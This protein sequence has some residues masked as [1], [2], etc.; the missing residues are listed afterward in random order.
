MNYN[1]G[2]ILTELERRHYLYLIGGDY[3]QLFYTFDH[4][5][6]TRD[7]L[8]FQGLSRIRLDVEVSTAERNKQIQDS[9]ADPEYKAMLDFM[10]KKRINARLEHADN[11]VETCQELVDVGPLLQDFSGERSFTSERVEHLK[12]CTWLVERLEAF[13]DNPQYKPYFN[14]PSATGIDAKLDVLGYSLFMWIMPRLTGEKIFERLHPSL[15]EV[16]GRIRR[17]NRLSS[18]AVAAMAH[19]ENLPD[20]EKWVL[21][22]LPAVN[23]MPLVIIINIIND[24]INNLVDQQRSALMSEESAGDRM[25]V[26][27]SYAFSG[28]ALYDLLSMEEVLKPHI[29]SEMKLNHFDPSPYLLGF[30]EDDSKLSDIFFKARAYA[31][32]RQLF[33]TGRIHPHETAIFLKKNSITKSVLKQLNEIELGAFATHVKLHEKLVNV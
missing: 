31:L 32:Y 14:L 8:Y 6:P 4:S 24:E 27:E 10:L 20:E 13:L 30:G 5:V 21:Y 29:V 19:Q 3:E 26:L 33:K 28:D 7:G 1:E 17:Y 12:Q 22:L 25:K 18:G 2:L 23:V 15:H 11:L 9:W 16:V